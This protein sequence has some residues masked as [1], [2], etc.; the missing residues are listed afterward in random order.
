MRF[1]CIHALVVQAAPVSFDALAGCFIAA[2]VSLMAAEGAT[3][4]RSGANLIAAAM[5]AAIGASQLSK[6]AV[7]AVRKALIAAG[8]AS[9]HQNGR[10]QV[11]GEKVEVCVK[12]KKKKDE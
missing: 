4:T 12:N 7:A 9:K 10:W 8:D 2:E 6:L 1:V 5:V 11:G 3:E